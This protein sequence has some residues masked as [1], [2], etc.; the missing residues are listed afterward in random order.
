MDSS[1]AAGSLD[2]PAEVEEHYE[3]LKDSLIMMVDDEPILMEVIQ[4]FLEE[5]GYRRFITCDQSTKALDLVRQHNPD[6]LLLDLVMP[7]V[8][9]FDI[10]A[11][12]KKVESTRHLPV[13]ILTSSNDSETKLKALDMGA[14]DFLAKPVDSSELALRLRNTLTVKA[15]QDRLT[16]FDQ[17]TGLPNRKYFLERLG[18][19][20]DEASHDEQEM[21]L[22]LV[23]L[24]RFK[25]IND[26]LG[27]SIG[28][29]ILVQVAARIKQVVGHDETSNPNNV[30]RLGGD[31]FSILLTDQHSSKTAEIAQS[32]LDEV[33]NPFDIEDQE[34]FVSA[35]IGIS[36]TGDVKNAD[37]LLQKASVAEKFAKQSGRN[38]FQ[39]YSSEIDAESR[40]RLDLEND[41][42]RALENN[43][44]ELYYQPKVNTRTRRIDGMEALIRWHHSTGELILPS[45][46]I[47]IAEESGQIV[48]IG[49]WIL[50]E[51]CKRSKELE[52]FG[53]NS[54]VSVNVSALQVADDNLCNAL[55][56]ALKVSNLAPNKLVIEI[57]ESAYMSDV[58]KSRGVLNDICATGASLSID[59]FGTGYSSLS[60]LKRLPI[61]E[62]KIDQSFL[63]DLPDNTDDAAIVRAIIAMA[64][65]L[66]LTVTAEGVETEAQVTF[67][68][69]QG[70]EVLQ[71]YF[72]SK[73]LPFDEFRDLCVKFI[74]LPWTRWQ[75]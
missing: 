61:A 33:G 69:A 38:T 71:G 14:M 29:E 42:R 11:A 47:P 34:I 10:L 49:E 59:D 44:L 37:E 46:F 65:S 16:N 8:T 2:Q 45:I 54:K 13:I 21:S 58:E 20:S 50:E 4:A 57:T 62:L 12:L 51:A 64:H 23:G 53:I 63:L 7:E 3:R 56:H 35:S 70:C 27:P 68:E 28:D 67:L 36:G 40:K 30:A 43:E 74:D 66:D 26:T 55:R 52:G 41:L 75:P 39:F 72:F 18:R 15:Y 22:L 60:Y 31:E 48:P 73:P 25:N 32:I 6:V 17:L 19:A 9:G 1:L 24:D 5:R